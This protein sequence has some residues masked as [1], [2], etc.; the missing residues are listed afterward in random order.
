M[1][2]TGSAPF[3]ADEDLRGRDLRKA[4]LRRCDLAGRDLS[5]ADLSLADLRHADLGNACLKGAKLT[6]ARLRQCV[7]RGADLAGADLRGADLTGADL[8]EACLTG[9]D[10]DGAYLDGANLE[11][12]DLSSAKA[13][14]LS[15]RDVSLRRAILGQADLT[16][17]QLTDGEL[18]DADLTGARLNDADLSFA[19]L[20]G[21]VLAGASLERADLSGANLERADLRDATLKDARLSWVLGLDPATRRELQER[22]A[23]VPTS[24]LSVPWARLNS[25]TRRHSALFYIVSLV[26]VVALSVAL[27]VWV[28]GRLAGEHVYPLVRPGEGT[29]YE[30][31]CGSGAD[32]VFH[33]RAG[34]IGGRVGMAKNAKADNVQRAGLAPAEAYLSERHGEDF[35]YRFR[36]SPGWYEVELHFA[37]FFHKSK[38]SR[39]FDISIE[40]QVVERNFDI[41]A[42]TYRATAVVRRWAARVDDGF[43]DLRF[44][45]R[46]ARAKVSFIRIRRLDRAVLRR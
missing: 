42:A 40:G 13:G 18:Q 27:A 41:L 31:D 26:L 11:A 7:M 30:V 32:Q 25:L 17:A 15:F 39:T 45:R 34:Y 16:G 28:A 3:S 33:G 36:A 23:R 46:R 6:G 12:A 10:L 22:G 4:R 24:W 1:V 8:T 5:E 9:A 14:G 35:G 43:L 38:G 2:R 20:R 19:D 37:E 21:A 44:K 29:V